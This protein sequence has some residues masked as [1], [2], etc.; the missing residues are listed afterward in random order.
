[1]AEARSA[2]PRRRASALSAPKSTRSPVGAAVF[3]FFL[4]GIGQCLNGQGAKGALLLLVFFLASSVFSFL[5]MGIP[6]L[7]VR[8]VAAADAYRIAEKRRR[9][10]AVRDGEWDLG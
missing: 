10:V 6:M 9:G 2:A 4:P 8:G 5:P 7:I 3:S 1:M